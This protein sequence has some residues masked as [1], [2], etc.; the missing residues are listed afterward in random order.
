MAETAS[1]AFPEGF[2][3]GAATAAYQIEGAVAE[4]G[5][6]PSIWDVQ[7]HTPGRTRDGDTGDVADDHYHRYR[8]DVALM[9]SLGLRG[10]RFSVAWPRVLPEG[11]G[12]VNEAGLDFYRRL[13]DELLAAGIQPHLTLYHWDLPQVIQDAGGWPSRDT[14][15]RFAD[16]AAVVFEALRDRVRF[17]TT[18]NEPWCSA[19]LGY[20]DGSHAPGFR[21]PT[22]ATPAIPS[23]SGTMRLAAIS[24]S[25]VSEA[26]A[27]EIEAMTTGEALMF[28]CDTSGL[29]P[30]GRDRALIASSMLRTD[31]STSVPY[32]NCATTKPMEL[33]DVEL[34]WSIPEIDCTARSIGSTTLVATS[35]AAAPGYGAMTVATGKETSGSSSCFRFVQATSPPPNS[36][37]ASS[38]VTV[39]R[40][41]ARREIQ[42]ISSIPRWLRGSC[43]SPRRPGG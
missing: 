8:E 11:G 22:L 19:L 42:V 28:S 37:A 25:S 5:R 9:R 21:D 7:S 24:P 31:A 29:T 6:A 39:R 35:S 43:R 32:S 18:L 27:D 3:W 26:L 38:R 34:T 14:A 20:A 23:S 13:V 36:A 15:Y 10:Y 1:L 4:D 2:L 16:Y 17:W 33:A 12:R 40:E 41:T 30:S